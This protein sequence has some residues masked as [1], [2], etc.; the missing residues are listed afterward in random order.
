MQ[1]VTKRVL[2]GLVAIIGVFSVVYLLF[3]NLETGKEQSSEESVSG[4]SSVVDETSFEEEQ[5]AFEESTQQ[6]EEEK[7][8][9]EPFNLLVCGTDNSGRLTDVIIVARIDLAQNS[10]SMLQI[11]RDTYV[12]EKY[13]TG[14]INAVYGQEGIEGL[15]KLIAERF[16]VE[17][18]HYAVISLKAFRAIVDEFGGITVNIP[19]RIVFTE[20]RVI[21][22]GV[23]TL[24]GEQAEWFVR[25]RAGYAMGDIGRMQAQE[26]F[27][28]AL[29]RTVMEK[30]GAELVL[31]A[32][33]HLGSIETDITLGRAVEMI[34]RR[35]E[36]EAEIISEI[37]PGEGRMLNGFAVY[38]PNEEKLAEITANIFENHAVNS[39]YED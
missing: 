33:R 18:D 35:E 27:L 3:F 32:G 17:T 15:K 36:G 26:L 28:R 5:S 16:S 13:P 9:E 21:E 34:E 11:P 22:K 2:F 12:G 29:M 8:A 23:Q 37:V 30:S 24:D 7:A 19:Q 38:I 39:G 4:S 14:K 10:I 31:A 1:S 20:D 6:S 25:Y